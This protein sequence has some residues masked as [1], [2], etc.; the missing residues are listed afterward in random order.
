MDSSPLTASSGG[1]F[2]AVVGGGDATRLD[3]PEAS[4]AEVSFFFFFVVVFD[5]GVVFATFV[6]ALVAA[7]TGR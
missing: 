1:C 7:S 3:S 4:L 6:A 2:T 5:S